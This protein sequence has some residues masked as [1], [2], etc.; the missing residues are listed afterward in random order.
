MRR[1][2]VGVYIGAQEEPEGLWPLLRGA[3]AG[4]GAGARVVFFAALFPRFLE[5]DLVL[6]AAGKGVRPAL[7]EVAGAILRRH[8]EEGASELSIFLGAVCARLPPG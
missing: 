4:A 2:S 8:E 1:G 3:G 5:F 7:D 6:R